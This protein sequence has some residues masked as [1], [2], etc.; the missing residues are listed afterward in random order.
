MERK[1]SST[2]ISGLTRNRGIRLGEATNS[3]LGAMAIWKILEDKYLPPYHPDYPER[4]DRKYSRTSAIFNMNVMRPIWE[5]YKKE[6]VS[7]IDKI[8]LGTT[9]DNVL[10]K[11][12]NIEKVIIAFE[13]FKGKTNLKEQV[14]IIREG[15]KKN[16]DVIAIGWNQT[17]VNENKW[18]STNFDEDEGTSLGY[19]LEKE[20]DHWY[21][22]DEIKV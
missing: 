13:D 6:E 11:I 9:F 8:V 15:L 16:E 17:S 3:W 1:M 14:N 18:D 19:N 12:E 20:T 2:Q 4:I 10:I 5:L 21:L 7:Y 22:F